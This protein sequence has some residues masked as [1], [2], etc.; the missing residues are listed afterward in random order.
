[1]MKHKIASLHLHPATIFSYLSSPI[2]KTCHF[3]RDS[4]N[5]FESVCVC[6]RGGGGG[7]MYAKI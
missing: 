5:K 4:I 7:R 3:H 2:L 1:M 6:V